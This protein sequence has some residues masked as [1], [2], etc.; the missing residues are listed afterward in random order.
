MVAQIKSNGLQPNSKGNLKGMASN[1]LAMA[2]NLRC[3]S[4][5]RWPDVECLDE[6]EAVV[7]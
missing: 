3:S 1:L 5:E 6:H 4:N 7:F 2:S